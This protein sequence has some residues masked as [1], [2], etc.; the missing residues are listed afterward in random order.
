MDEVK[1]GGT[2]AVTS[3]SGQGVIVQHNAYLY[4][5][6]CDIPQCQWKILPTTL[7]KYVEYATV[8]A[9]PPGVGC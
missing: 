5:L 1:F 7:Q 8:L 4:E 2:R 9:L 3:P 6:E